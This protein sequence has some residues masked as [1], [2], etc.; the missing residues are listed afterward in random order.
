MNPEVI[1][2]IHKLIIKTRLGSSEDF[3]ALYNKD[4]LIK[5]LRK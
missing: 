5:F 1:N 4:N 2:Y 3:L